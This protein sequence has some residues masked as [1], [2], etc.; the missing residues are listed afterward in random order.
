MG[1]THYWDM[2][3]DISERNFKKL[4]NDMK[5]IEAYVSKIDEPTEQFTLHNANGE[6]DGVLYLDNQFCFNGDAEQGADHESM[7]IRLGANN[8]WTFCKTARKPYDLAVCL[9]LLSLK[10]HIRSTRVSSDGTS[11]DWEL[12][13]E[14]WGKIF[15]RRSVHLYFKKWIKGDKK[16]DGSLA[17]I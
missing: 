15:P 4:T 1:Y 3:R 13:L 10:Y 16:L 11:E 12:A 8:S 14:T 2:S 7:H 6:N 17:I 5:A 9:I